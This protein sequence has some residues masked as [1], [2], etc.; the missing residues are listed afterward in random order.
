MAPSMTPTFAES[1]DVDAVLEMDEI[2][3]SAEEDLDES[4]ATPTGVSDDES[5]EFEAEND[6]DLDD[7]QFGA[8]D[9]DDHEGYV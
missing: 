7:D 4:G 6:D 1:D 9:D 3:V 8:D 5:E 2:E